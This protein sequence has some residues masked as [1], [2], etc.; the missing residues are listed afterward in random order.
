VQVEGLRG[1]VFRS[2]DWAGR[3]KDGERED[4]RCIG[5]ADTKVCQRHTKVFRIGKLLLSIYS[6]LCINSQTIT[7][8]G[9]EGSKVGIDGTTGR[10]I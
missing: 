2:S 7:Q 1:E 4:K 9:K 6:R 3:Y 5:I 8:Y 10:S